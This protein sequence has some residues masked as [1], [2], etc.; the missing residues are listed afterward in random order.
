MITIDDCIQGN[1]KQHLMAKCLRG[2]QQ[3]V[4]LRAFPSIEAI[5]S[6]RLNKERAK[7][8]GGSRALWANEIGSHIDNLE[9][10]GWLTL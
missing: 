4:T 8:A 1:F 3:I 10:V 5:V 7:A 6:N 2:N 9:I